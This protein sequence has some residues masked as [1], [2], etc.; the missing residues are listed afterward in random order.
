MTTVDEI[1]GKPDT[2]DSIL[3]T[4]TIDD[5]LGS[6]EISD[7]PLVNAE[8]AAAPTQ[9]VHPDIQAQEIDELSRAA[10]SA[11]VEAAASPN[12][13][14]QRRA[15]ALGVQL[16]DREANFATEFPDHPLTRKIRE[17]SVASNVLRQQ[18]VPQ[19]PNAVQEAME[20]PAYFIERMGL[21]ALPLAGALGGARMMTSVAPAGA[22]LLRQAATQAAPIAGAVAGGGLTA[23]AQEKLLSAGETPEET[24]ARHDRSTHIGT[25]PAG[26]LADLATMSVAFR[27]SLTALEAAAAGDAAAIQ[28][29]AMGGAVGGTMATGNALL[30]GRELT[31]KEL[32]GGI[33]EGALFSKPTKLGA[34][35]LGHGPQAPK[36]I[37]AAEARKDVETVMTEKP[38]ERPMPTISANR[39]IMES[40]LNRPLTGEE[41]FIVATQGLDAVKQLPK[42]SGTLEAGYREASGVPKAE[43]VGARL[44]ADEAAIKEFA[45]PSLEQIR[46]EGT[47]P[48]DP[49]RRLG[50]GAANIEEFGPQKTI[51][52][53]NAEVDAQRVERGLQP[54]MSEARK[55]DTT[56]WDNAE[57][58]IEA[59]PQYPDKL[60]AEITG[61]QK[62][63]ITDEEQAAL[64][65]QRN[66]LRTRA[67]ME[68]ERLADES[69]TP[70]ERADA[71]ASAALL[72][73]KLAANE[74]ANRTAGT[75][76]GRALRS[77]QLEL[78]EDFTPAAMV[79]RAR[80]AKGESLTPE[81]RAT[82][83]AEGETIQKA[84][85]AQAERTVAVDEAQSMAAAKETARMEA[86]PTYSERFVKWAESKLAEFDARADQAH[87][88]LMSLFG[89]QTNIGGG[90]PK[91]IAALFHIA[92]AK[93]ARGTYDVGKFTADMIGAY[94]ELVK[95]FIKPAWDQATK[96]FEKAPGAP[97]PPSKKTVAKQAAAA[98]E[99]DGTEAG[100]A[101]VAES[102][103]KSLDEFAPYI[104]KLGNEYARSGMQVEAIE[105]KLHEVFSPLI[106][107]VTPR[108]LRDTWTTY[109]QGKSAPTDPAAVAQ[110]QRRGEGQKISALED[111]QAKLNNLELEG[112]KLTGDQRVPPSDRARRLQ[113]Q[114]TEV[115][116]K[117]D[118]KKAE[119]GIKDEPTERQLASALESMEK[120]TENRIRDLRFEIAKGERILKQKNESPTSPRLEAL[121]AELAEVQA[122][123]QSVFGRREL[124]PE[125]KL[126]SAIAAAERAEVAANAELADA[127]KGIFKKPEVKAAPAREVEAIRARV[128][129]AKEET[130][131]LKKLAN[132]PL[133]DAQKALDRA[134][135]ARERWEQV[136]AGEIAPAKKVP[137]EALTQLEEDARLEIG[138][139]RKLAAEMRAKPLSTEEERTLKALEKA[140]AEYE[141]RLNDADF[142][143][144]SG[145]KLGPDTPKVAQARAVRDAAKAA[146][147]AAR[148]AAAPPTKS[149]DEIAIQG[150]KT[151]TAR[152]IAD[153][154][155]R[156]A[157]GDFAK[158]ERK[159]LDLSKDAEAVKLKAEADAAKQ[160]FNKRRFE[161]E[162]A[163]RS[164]TRKV[165][166][167]SKEVLGATR[168]LITSGDVSAPGRQGGFLLIGDLVLNP[169][170]AVK[171]I[172]KMFH[173]MASEKAFNEAEAAIRMRPNAELY[174]SAGLHLSDP[175]G[176][177]TQREENMRSNLAEQ[178]P[179]AGR[180]VKGSNRAYAGFLNRQRADAF[181]AFVE[182][183]GGK[184]NIHADEAKFLAEAVNDLTGRSNLTSGKAIG[185]A[186]WLAR[187]LFSPRFLMSR[188][189]V[190]VGAPVFRDITNGNISPKARAVVALQYAKFAA[191]LAALYG[192][193]K[194]SGAE[195]ELDPRSSDFGKAK[196][197]NTRLDAMAGLQ[198]VA[199]FLSRMFSG[200]T[201]TPKGVRSIR[202][203]DDDSP[204]FGDR[205]A[206]DVA[207][208]FGRSKLA[209]IPATAVDWLQ[210]QTMDF[211]RP[212]L[213]GTAQRLTVPI[214]YQDAPAIMREQGFAKGAV[215]EAL[216]LLGVGVQHYEPRK[217]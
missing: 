155:E 42:E 111:L 92:K 102:G 190:L 82:V 44:Q 170:R 188:F 138:A 40:G 104:K 54:L 195:V 171:Q 161:W 131:L 154:A 140:T 33:A 25:T 22:S 88:D 176:K 7:I 20:S 126:K 60:V 202:V 1:L 162:Q 135:V 178:I 91:A 181:D 204:K 147:D 55:A 150:Y 145:R 59:D 107:G 26:K 205:T 130:A 184:D 186:D 183:I 113:K 63:S 192:L 191:G 193:A 141:Q 56:T 121:R 110:A 4:Q 197:G 119:L 214:G 185:V 211:E 129:A 51:S 83:I 143:K 29:L 72:E 52:G 209:P 123:H 146:L 106:E 43:E 65:W 157:K 78:N 156:T 84:E 201:K 68:Y 2:V 8:P 15:D 35:L 212:T 153:L 46:Q 38:A 108:E 93:L 9:R 28:N 175:H 163:K 160:E 81:E 3:G 125:Q 198:Q 158:K 6:E 98:A 10:A 216:N 127:R 196:F 85:A 48:P 89:Q 165:I 139:M 164:R 31:G 58:R 61:G 30:E 203:S 99:A 149:K 215:M 62:K 117:I 12:I 45:K 187:Y 90:A 39:S 199:V 13:A 180:I 189:K 194:L 94:G 70:E 101:V 66:D 77:R 174:D 37:T 179:I 166:D 148:K 41:A 19:E 75:A 151:R 115:K 80:T 142:S 144:R 18:P 109:G 114:I 182:M 132:P 71:E 167:A 36:R 50:P 177:F 23:L 17:A 95:P 57:R 159:Q 128:K 124:T 69:L 103:A 118:A 14:A 11:S 210:G 49:S 173:V 169:K 133:S 97:K 208:T 74:E 86:S 21:N 137:R 64:V 116:K 73:S 100:V 200:Q 206:V 122:E 217:K 5:I 87:R 96:F 47:T 213:L 105:A 34:R 16:M 27:P 152:R 67:T 207:A 134:M 120:R 24:Q 79:G 172:G 53:R 136:L 112:A 32:A 168:T 76:S